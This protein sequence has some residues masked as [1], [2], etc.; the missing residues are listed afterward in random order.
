[1]KQTYLYV[2]DKQRTVEATAETEQSL[3]AECEMM[4]KENE[5][6]NHLQSVNVTFDREVTYKLEEYLHQ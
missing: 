2:I 6:L 4:R 3:R 5:K 1:M